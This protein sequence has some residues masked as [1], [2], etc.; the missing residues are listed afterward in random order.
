ML[1]SRPQDV[2]DDIAICL[3]FY[4]RLPVPFARVGERDFASA[5]W[6][7]PVAGLAVGLVGGF[8]FLVADFLGQPATVAAALAVASTVFVT[9]ALH[10]DGLSDTADG[11]GGG[12]TRE[13]KLEIMRD[14][15][16]GTF[17]AT[18]LMFSILLRWSALAALAAP[19]LAFCALIA[20]HAAGR[21]AM[22][23]FMRL[24]PPARTD[25]LSAT[26]G[27][28]PDSTVLLAGSVAGAILLFTLGLHAAVLSILALALLFFLLRRLC[29]NQIGGQTG[30]VLGALEQLSEIAVLMI[31]SAILT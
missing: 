23:A 5:Q 18:A 19:S 24:A 12:G 8:V 14:S 20:S 16:I 4:T 17:G 9:G 7:A 3:A 1:P 2:V 13:R 21:A 27:A 28:V 26:A 6:A 29:E 30:D 10:E 31:A 11:F 25:G 15:R 22:P